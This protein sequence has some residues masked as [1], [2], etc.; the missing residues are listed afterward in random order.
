MFMN[1][2]SVFES[3]EMTAYGFFSINLNLVM[4]VSM[5]GY[6]IISLIQ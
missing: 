6:I 2:V 1:Q 5:Y 4:S 3:N